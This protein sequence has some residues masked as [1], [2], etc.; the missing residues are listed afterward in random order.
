MTITTAMGANLDLLTAALDDPGADIAHSL[1][2]LTL[3]AVDAVPSY[4]GL[5]VAV[6]QADFPLTLTSLSDGSVAD[7]RTTLCWSLPGPGDSRNSLAVAIILYAGSPGAFVDLAADLSWLAAGRLGDFVLDQ[8]LTISPG[9]LIEGQLH[10]ASAINQAIGLLIGR[11]YTPQQADWQ[12]DTQAAN[13]RTDRHSAARLILATIT[14]SD[15]GH[16]DIP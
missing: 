9:P 1:H 14:T 15:D 7:V 16:V 2:Q 5:S 11:G 13:N 3:M 10:A 8:H 12:L 6:P 4:L